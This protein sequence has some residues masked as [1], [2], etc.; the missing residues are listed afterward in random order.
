[1][2]V[3]PVA[4]VLLVPQVGP[5]QKVDKGFVQLFNGKDLAG[6]KQFAGKQGVWMVEDSIIVC[7]GDGGG[8]LGTEKEYG[9]FELKLE[10]RLQ[11]GGNSGVYIRAP[12]SGHISRD[13][14]EIQILDDLHPK[15]SKLDFYQ[16]TGS[17]YHVVAPNKRAT[18]PAGQW[19][20]MT[21]RADGS[22]IKVWLNGHKIVDTDLE[23]WRADL[24]IAKEHPGLA[25]KTGHVGLQS[26]T[27][28]VEFRDLQ[29]KDLK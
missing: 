19:N 13:G 23:R 2:Y 28:R 4:L 18:K 7:K 27:D 11:P 15:Y 20:A 12:K 5:S 6:W 22:D 17:I 29:I 24:A 8:W 9:N 26:H 14:M 10:Y 21:I 25:R 1:M 3:L 16:Y